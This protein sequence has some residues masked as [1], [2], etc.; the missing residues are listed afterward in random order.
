MLE[1][2]PIALGKAD[3][4]DI[5]SVLHGAYRAG[6]GFPRWRGEVV[7]WTAR[8]TLRGFLRVAASSNNSMQPTAL[9]AAADAER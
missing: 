5:G 1:V 8:R 7:S 2:L 3:I 9:R 6:V 4:I